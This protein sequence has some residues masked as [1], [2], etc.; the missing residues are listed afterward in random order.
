MAAVTGALGTGPV[1]I[2][3]GDLAFANS[4]SAGNLAI[5]NRGSLTFRDIISRCGQGDQHRRHQYL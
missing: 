3:A 1:V 5:A 4:A 2:D